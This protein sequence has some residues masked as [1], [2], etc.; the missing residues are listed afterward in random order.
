MGFTTYEKPQWVSYVKL[1]D[2]YHY[3]GDKSLIEYMEKGPYN[4]ELRYNPEYHN[5]DMYSKKPYFRLFFRQLKANDKKRYLGYSL[6][7]Q[8]QID[9]K[10]YFHNKKVRDNLPK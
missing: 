4:E 9:P 2:R 7:P 1:P 8:E 6:N 3:I 5:D 10:F